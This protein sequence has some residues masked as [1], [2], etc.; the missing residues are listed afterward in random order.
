[1]SRRPRLAV[2]RTAFPTRRQ[3]NLRGRVTRPARASPPAAPAPSAGPAR[4][5]GAPT[6]WIVA[7]RLLRFGLVLATGIL[8]LIGLLSVTR[9]TPIERLGAPAG[10]GTFPAV[11]TPAFAQAVGLL[12]GA[13]LTPGNH[14]ELLRDGDGTYPRLWADLRAARRSVTVQLY[15][16]QPGAVADTMARILA[17]K[18]R[19]GVPVLLVLDDFGFHPLARSWDDSLRAA[20]VRVARLREMRWYRLDRVGGRSHVRAVVVDGVVGYTGGFGLA[21]YWLGDGRTPGQWRETNVR[22]EG[23]AVAQLQAAFMTAWA[24]AEGQLLAGEPWFAAPTRRDTAAA[25]GGAGVRAAHAVRHQPLLPARRRLPALPRRRGGPRRGRA[26]ADR[27]HADGHP[28]GLLGEPLALR[29]AAA[30]RRPHLRVPADDDAREDAGRRR[31]VG[32]R[33]LDELRQPLAGAERGVEPDR[34]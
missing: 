32:R 21:D 5:P 11:G 2:V 15:Y 12:T 31:R 3:M 25:A 1:M 9:G 28:L 18:A 20:G 6:P 4:D 29:T 10:A 22:F 26:R 33:R 8:A 27:E 24:E 23:P 7:G 17:A 16:G 13:R 30:G 19:E 34:A 14:V